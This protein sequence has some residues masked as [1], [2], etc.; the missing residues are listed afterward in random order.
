VSTD[1]SRLKRDFRKT[2]FQNQ[3]NASTTFMRIQL[4]WFSLG[5]LALQIQ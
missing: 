1:S 4:E 2:H 5:D 3:P